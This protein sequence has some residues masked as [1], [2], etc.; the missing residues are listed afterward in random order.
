MKKQITCAV[1]AR[2]DPLTHYQSQNPADGLLL[3]VL[4]ET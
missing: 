1:G 4:Q 3:L 2:G